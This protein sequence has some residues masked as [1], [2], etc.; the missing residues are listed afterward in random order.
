MPPARMSCCNGSDAKRVGHPALAR[1]RPEE[2]VVGQRETGVPG[3]PVSG[4][5]WG[6]PHGAPGQTGL[7][8]PG[9]PITFG[10]GHQR[11]RLTEQAPISC[12]PGQSAAPRSMRKF[13]PGGR[14]RPAFRQGSCAFT[15]S[16]FIGNSP[17]AGAQWPQNAPGNRAESSHP[18]PEILPAPWRRIEEHDDSRSRDRHH[19]EFGTRPIRHAAT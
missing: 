8:P 15:W 7:A 16:L 4:L 17:T 6:I 14:F 18:H 12:P 19:M 9:Q 10:L 2:K 5:S 11:P 3:T 1:H 13:L